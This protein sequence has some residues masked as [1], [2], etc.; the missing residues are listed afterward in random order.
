V[1]LE[2]S[3]H[4][5]QT[6]S[7]TMAAIGTVYTI[8]LVSQIIGEDEEWLEELSIFMEPEDGRLYVSG[9]HDE[10]ITAFTNFGIENLRDIIIATR[11]SMD[12]K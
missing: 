7:L 12:K 9:M 8:S 11:E 5:D 10:T 6:G 4:G 1:E 2:D 3:K